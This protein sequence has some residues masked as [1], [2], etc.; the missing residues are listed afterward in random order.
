[1][2]ETTQLYYDG[3]VLNNVFIDMRPPAKVAPWPFRRKLCDPESSA[4][5]TSEECWNFC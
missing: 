1:M 3:F 5:H 2:R 4:C